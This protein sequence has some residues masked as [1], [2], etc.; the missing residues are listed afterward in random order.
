MDRS[1]PGGIDSRGSGVVG[2]Y[3]VLSCGDAPLSVL[4]Q[5]IEQQ[6]KGVS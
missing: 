2:R 3:C 5:Y 1:W 6:G 4:R